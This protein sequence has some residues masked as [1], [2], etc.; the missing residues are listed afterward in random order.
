MALMPTF[1]GRGAMIEVGK[2]E[3]CRGLCQSV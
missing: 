1:S 3:D 2:K